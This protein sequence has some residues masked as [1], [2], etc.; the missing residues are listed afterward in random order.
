M[1]FLIDSANYK[2]I[3]PLRQIG[4][5]IKKEMKKIIELMNKSWSFKYKHGATILTS[6]DKPHIKWIKEI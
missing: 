5:E 2:T 3:I 1:S 6:K 4:I